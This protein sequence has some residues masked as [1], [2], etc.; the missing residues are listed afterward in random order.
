MGREEALGAVARVSHPFALGPLE[1]FEAPIDWDDE[2]RTYR[3]A[4]ASG[5][6]ILDAIHT[7]HEIDL[8][9]AAAIL[10]VLEEHGGRIET[11]GEVAFGPTPTGRRPFTERD[12]ARYRLW[13]QQCWPHVRALLALRRDLVNDLGALAD[14]R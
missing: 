2:W 6:G 12:R 8:A 14:A 3:D 10:S 4:R 7:G 1:E 5:E 9:E 11:N 13:V